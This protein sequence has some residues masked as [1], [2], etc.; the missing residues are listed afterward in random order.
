MESPPQTSCPP[1]QASEP[2]VESEDADRGVGLDVVDLVNPAVKPEFDF[3]LA[4]HLVERGSQLSGV[5][6]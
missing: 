5:L 2:S 6:A 1:G 4:M 3:V